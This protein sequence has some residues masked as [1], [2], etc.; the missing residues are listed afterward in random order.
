MT[1]KEDQQNNES[2]K[3]GKR[4]PDEEAGSVTPLSKG[5]TGGIGSR[6]RVGVEGGSRVAGA[7]QAGA[8]LYP[9][10]SGQLKPMAYSDLPPVLLL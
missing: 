5:G 9:E 7:G 1:F 4:I 10:C 8:G 3:T 2:Q 6:V